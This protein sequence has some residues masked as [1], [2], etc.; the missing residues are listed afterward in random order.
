MD[1][2]YRAVE[3]LKDSKAIVDQ[4]KNQALKVDKEAYKDLIK[5]SDSINKLIDQRID[6]M[7]G[8]EDKRQGITAAKDP[9][10]ISYLNDAINYVSSLRS[11]PGATETRL[12]E[13]ANARID[14]VISEINNF[15]QMEWL[16]YRKLVENTHLSVFKDYKP[17]Q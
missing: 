1:L 4:I 6:D 8:K 5:A 11:E 10:T 7:L 15:Y 14:P 12:I 16:D 9:S 3:R 2:S 13:N 17:L